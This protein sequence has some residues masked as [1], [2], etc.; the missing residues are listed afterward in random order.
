MTRL[1]PWETSSR[2]PEKKDFCWQRWGDFFCCCPASTTWEGFILLGPQ[3][4]KVIHP[5]QISEI[6]SQHP[7]RKDLSDVFFFYFKD[8]II[9]REYVCLILSVT[10]GWRKGKQPFEEIPLSLK[11][12]PGPRQILM[13]LSIISP[14]AIWG[15]ISGLVW[16]SWLPPMKT[17]YL[18]LKVIPWTHQWNVVFFGNLWVLTV[19]RFG[20]SRRFFSQLWRIMWT[21]ELCMML[22]GF[23]CLGKRF[24]LAS[25]ESFVS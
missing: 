19:G 5:R 7:K 8:G 14:P 22:L 4:S 11:K 16:E 6:N 3:L 10:C 2:T 12:V 23:F 25:E 1:T 24:W 21:S 18:I 9:S 17:K 15:Q 13:K 20:G